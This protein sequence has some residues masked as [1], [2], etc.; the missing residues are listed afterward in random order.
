MLDEI[1]TR[2]YF[3]KDKVIDWVFNDIKDEKIK[4]DDRAKGIIHA[5]ITSHGFSA[6]QAVFYTIELKKFLG[7]DERIYENIFISK[8][9]S[10]KIAKSRI[11]RV[12]QINRE[13]RKLRE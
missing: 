7:I 4:S 11:D 5:W 10:G 3:V 12:N 6:L 9:V 1:L 13:R 8:S 2:K